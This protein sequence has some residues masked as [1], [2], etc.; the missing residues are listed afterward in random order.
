MEAC[1]LNKY[2]AAAGLCSRREAD[3][4]IASGRILIDGKP[5]E[6]GQQVD[7]TET[8]LLDGKPLGCGKTAAEL[9]TPAPVLLLFNKP[10]G[11]VCTAGHKDRAPNVIDYIHYGTR[12]YPIGR[13]D[14]E[15][16]GLLLLTNQGALVNQINR[17]R[18]GHEKEYL[19]GCRHALTA[20]FLRQLAAGVE[21]EVPRRGKGEAPYKLRT[22]ACK[23]TQVDA[24]HFR[25]I[26]TQGLNRQIRRMC[27][28]LGNE[29]V[30][31]RRLRVMN[32]KL[33][34]LQV[35]AYRSATEAEW[36]E[37]RRLLAVQVEQGETGHGT[38]FARTV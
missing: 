35:G 12:I 13:L 7:G 5:A 2:L 34:A 24:H 6:A 27:A 23:V 22:R 28:A 19:V 18:Y 29:V 9:Q 11:L 4:L 8:I 21:I 33:G 31:L 3:R 15:S 14:K 10:R 26:L 20:R 38:D 32:L 1:R 25:I 17:A 16:E 37:L 30:L 36:T